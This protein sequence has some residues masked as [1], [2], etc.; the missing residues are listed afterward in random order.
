MICYQSN[1]ALRDTDR[2]TFELRVREGMKFIEKNHPGYRDYVLTSLGIDRRN[3]TSNTVPN[4][5]DMSSM[6]V[7]G[8]A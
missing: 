7:T 3:C 6:F 4:L 8:H 5:K 1:L 2:D